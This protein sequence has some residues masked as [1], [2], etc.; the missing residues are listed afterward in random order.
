[1][2]RLTRAIRSICVNEVEIRV[3]RE[4]VTV[5]WDGQSRSVRP[6][7]HLGTGPGRARIVGIGDTFGSLEPSVALPVFGPLPAGV[8]LATWAEVVTQF[9]DYTIKQARRS[10]VRSE[11]RRVG[12]ECRSRWG[13]AH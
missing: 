5:S 6:V 8:S 10:M 3:S 12:K 13:P 4:L 1:M 2:K 11:E 9:M 7:V